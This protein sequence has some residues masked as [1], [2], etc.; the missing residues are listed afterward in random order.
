M[1]LAANKFAET[2]LD[3]TLSFI[4]PIYLFF[5]VVCLKTLLFY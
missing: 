4:P 2:T 1:Y 3:L 5:D